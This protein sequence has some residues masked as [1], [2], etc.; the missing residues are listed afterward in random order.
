MAQAV[1]LPKLGQTM[2]EGAIVKWHKKE[3]DPVKKGDI[4]FEIETDKAALEVESFFEG[5]LIKI[6]IGESITVPVNT[7][8]AYVGEKGEKAPD[9][10]A[11]VA[12]P[13][14]AEAKK[15]EPA[16]A[17]V[18]A[19]RPAIAAGAPA[20]APK[21]AP[22]PVPQ[23]AAPSRVFI[24]PRAK[25]IVKSAVI[26]PARIKGSGPEG[27]IVEKDVMAY[28]EKMGYVSLKITPA[29]KNLAAK[30]GIDILAVRGTGEGGKIRIEDVQKAVAEK[31]KMMSKM[32]QVIARRLTESFTSVPHFYVTVSVD[33]TDL[34]VFRQELKNKGMAFTVTDF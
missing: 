17:V 18:E 31:P 33:M 25:V 27:R 6:L 8:V 1:I 14:P 5:T 12:A 26:N 21:A 28:L 30:E 24:S 20:P 19:P 16:K 2:E 7:V 9:Q 23:A 29:A 13:K 22:K 4:L 15:A 10:P 34:L 32:R 3:G 11:V